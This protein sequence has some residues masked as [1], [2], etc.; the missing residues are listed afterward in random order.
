MPGLCIR[1][2]ALCGLAVGQLSIS[3]AGLAQTTNWT[4][5]GSG[6]WT[7]AGNWDNGVP[8]NSLTAA[9]EN[10]GTAI[11]STAGQTV[12]DWQIGASGSGAAIIQGGGA[13]TQ[14]TGT[15]IVG[16]GS[17]T[18]TGSGSSF[19]DN[20]DLL[21]GRNTGTSGVTVEAGGQLT[22]NRSFIGE[23]PGA[24]TA[25]TITALLTGPG[26]VWNAGTFFGVGSGG[27]G[28]TATLTIANGG[29]LTAQDPVAISSIG[30][31][32]E[33]SALVTG[34]GSALLLGSGTTLA[35]GEFVNGGGGTGT[36][37]IQNGGLVSAPTI[38][39]GAFDPSATG[40]LNLDGTAGARGVLV[41][42]ALTKDL[43]SASVSFDG[44][45]LRASADSTDFIAG[46]APGSLVIQSGGLFVDTN[47][48]AVEAS[49][50]L[51]GTGALVKQGAG[52]LTLS[53]ANAYTGGTTVAAGT[54]AIGNG[55]TTGSILGDVVVGTGATLAFNRSDAVSFPGAVSGGGALTQQG[56]GTLTLTGAN[57]YS[58]GTIVAAGTLAIG[59]GGTAGSILGDI[60]VDAG[61]VLAF[62]RSD[63]ITFAGT[64]S[65]AGTLTQLGSGTLIL[66]GSNSYVG[67]TIVAA[68]TLAIG[69]GGTAGSIGGNV[70]IGTGATLMFDR[71]DDVT[72]AGTLS[73]P[74]TLVQAGG[75]TLTLS[76]SNS[77]GGTVVT[78]GALAIASP[79]NLGPGFLSLENGTSVLF[80]GSGRYGQVISIAGDPS[81][82]VA[83]GQTVTIASGIAGTGELVKIDAGTLILDGGNLYAGATTVA[84]GTLILGDR[85]TPTAS[86]A[87][88]AAVE[89]GAMLAG[90]GTV[91]GSLANAGLVLPGGPG[92]AI[93]T[94]R[95]A[96]AYT[97]SAAGTLA[98]N[99]VPAAASQL[100]VSGTASLTGTVGFAY[101]AG[102]YQPGLYPVLTSGSGVD[103][104]F[105]AIAETGAVPET[106]LR[107]VVYTQDQVDLVLSLPTIGTA[108]GS[109]IFT[110]TAVTLQDNTQDA[111][112]A[113][114][115]DA[116]QFMTEDGA[117]C[118]M[119]QDLCLWADGI[120]HFVS[121]DGTGSTSGFDADAGGFL[122]GLHRAFDKALL[123]IG[124]G[125]ERT[126]LWTSFAD[127]D[128]D[129]ARLFLYGDLDLAPVTLSGTVG[130]AH[131]W[132]DTHRDG[133]SGFLNDAGAARE[134]H[135]A[136]DYSAGIQLSLPARMGDVALRPKAGLQYAAIDEAAFHEAG[137][138]MLDV[139]GD[140]HERDS[141]RSFI[142]VELS[143]AIALEGATLVPRL[144][145]DYA[146]EL[147]P[148]GSSGLLTVDGTSGPR[149]G[150][151][152]ATRNIVATGAGLD[153]VLGTM[154]VSARY[155]ADIYT[156]RGLD[157]IVRLELRWQL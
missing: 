4:N 16:T 110:D 12:G 116:G 87:G 35:I 156:G 120:G 125:Y 102:A 136:S 90:Y 42:A 10:G 89:S 99:V 80:T 62:N 129:T 98:I 106:L 140:S 3:G 21:I 131:D 17:L 150:N 41:T 132:I 103:G 94:L 39:M 92:A 82:D 145:I 122:V 153:L 6:N 31:G 34:A 49:S 91:G 97:Q 50:G 144:D 78:A 157:Q 54:L 93:G 123:G 143:R 146:H 109:G 9:I 24:A 66:I 55:G 33:G 95:V 151:P 59:N 53:G 133:S 30:L 86:I 18:V 20:D 126:S 115:D 118:T 19:T 51:S 32:G 7:S 81:F 84:A 5:P 45:I 147:L 14:M 60:V 141:L 134:S 26:S 88:S 74:G 155:D 124:A 2:L 148:Q 44:G 79:A 8:N 58:G 69:N 13:L 23:G 85:A 68:G 152:L 61:A 96:G 111:T 52:T 135:D 36:L 113:L 1:K 63:A 108:V 154:S 11:V 28:A 64:V 107:S 46:F 47:G 71:S 76:G 77:Q 101:G 138:D 83:D 67:G 73:G 70:A 119:V 114:L 149:P 48:F 38:M 105:T 112:S 25:T 72:F 57:S 65:G 56:S 127:G 43:G 128:A 75:G 40:T 100:L 104:R 37:T 142:G 27:A 130:Y 121:A 117:R 137:A 15:T 22:T 139:S 29:V